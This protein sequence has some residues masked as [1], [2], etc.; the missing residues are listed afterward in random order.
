MGWKKWEKKKTNLV[1][2]DA[3]IIHRTFPNSEREGKRV[4]F[5]PPRQIHDH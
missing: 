4:F 5:P 1:S 2:I 3:N